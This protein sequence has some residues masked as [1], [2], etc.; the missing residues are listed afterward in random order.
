M[1]AKPFT[2]VLDAVSQL[3]ILCVFAPIFEE[4]LF[5]GVMLSHHL[6]YGAWHA[7]I[8]SALYFGLFHANLSQL[9]Y[10]F[11]GGLFLAM[12]TLKTGSIIPSIIIH[13]LLNFTSYLQLVSLSLIDNYDAY[14]NGVDM[15]PKGSPFAL[16]L[17]AFT[18]LLPWILM[19]AAVIMLIVELVTNKATFRMPQ[20]DS[21]LTAREKANAYFTV[22]A[23]WV[24]ITVGI[25]AIIFQEILKYLSTHAS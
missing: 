5:R 1:T 6:K 19:I 17:Y 18:T 14:M 4:L 23:A 21:G 15:L 12:V 7:C 10:T 9:P 22:P 2:S 16:V 25:L 24:A 20:G 3:V 8:I 13:T 11:V